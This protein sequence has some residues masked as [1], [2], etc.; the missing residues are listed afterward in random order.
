PEDAT[1]IECD[2][3]I[4]GAGAAGITIARSFA[5]GQVKVCLV[6][7]GGPEFEDETQALYMGR[8][9]G[10]PYF[11]LD[12]T[13]LRYFGGSTN[14]WEGRCRPLDPIDLEARDW[15]PLSGWPIGYA[16]LDP[17]YRQA[18]KVCKLAAFS[19][20]PE[21]WVRDLQE[22]FPADAA[23]LVNR[24]WQ[25]RPLRFGE[26]YRAELEAAANIEVLLHANLVEI[27]TTEAGSLV[28][29]VRLA[30]VDGKGL[31]LRPRV[32]VLACG[33]L[34]TP[35]LL[36]ASNRIVNV[37][38]G[39][40]NDMVGRCFMEHPNLSSGRALVVG[41]EIL[42]FY[43]HG[44][45]GARAGEVHIVGCI[46][47]SPETQRERQALNFDAL[48]TIDHVGDSGYAALRR[49]W[50]SAERAR[51]PDDLS[52]DLWQALIDPGDTV[53]GLLGRFGLREY[54]PDGAS[55]R[56]WC[57]AEQAP[58][59]DSRVLLGDEV[60]PLGLPR[61]RLDWRLSEL[62]K[63]SFQV[64]HDTIAQELGR[65]G[66]G[67]LQV[68]DWVNEDL[69]SWPP[70][71]EGGHHHLGTAR[72]S[73]SAAQGVVDRHCRLHG[74]DNLYVAGSAVFPTGGSANPTLTIVALS[75]RLAGELQRRLA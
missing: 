6:E 8:N 65:T 71:L 11:D 47:L 55:F 3:A 66:L 75:L 16:D 22:V 13:R 67:R 69:T 34:E 42:N 45:G 5:D 21:P 12:V 2:L 25:Y 60:D 7:S 38:L 23:K 10:L 17:Y 57:T 4:V 70:N 53:A 64:A 41:P 58:N 14:H 35:R 68:S 73:E 24:V 49:I 30:T 39:N 50:N 36:L 32:V 40:Q 18:Q 46:N 28:T 9:V 31:A 27:E 29:G 52:G 43:T 19:Y 54:R 74:V 63:H 37:G 26:V 1:T 44:T 48:F 72:M 51:W 61:L 15:V 20:T 56:L 59:P 33:G 62:D